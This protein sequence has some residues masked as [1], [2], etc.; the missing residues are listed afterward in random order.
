MWRVASLT[1]N[2]SEP[3]EARAKARPSMVP[4]QPL[5]S[6]DEIGV[7][8]RR[9]EPPKDCNAMFMLRAF[10]LM[11]ACDAV[12]LGPTDRHKTE[13]WRFEAK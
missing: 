11:M 10:A 2:Q 3:T 7:I 4:V 13:S 9:A 12:F 6:V 5:C 1:E 8:R